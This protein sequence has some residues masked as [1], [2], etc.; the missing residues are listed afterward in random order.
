ML[1]LGAIFSYQLLGHT[2]LVNNAVF[3]TSVNICTFILPGKSIIPKPYSKKV[4]TL[5]LLLTYRIFL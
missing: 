1:W 3:I 2:C 4:N 5:S